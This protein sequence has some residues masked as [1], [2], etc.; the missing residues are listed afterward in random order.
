MLGQVDRRTLRLHVGHVHLGQFDRGEV[1]ADRA[2][3]D[4]AHRERVADER[5]GVQAGEDDRFIAGRG[6][7]REEQVDV[8]GVGD[9]VRVVSD[10]GAD[11]TVEPPPVRL[12]PAGVGLE[13][14]EPEVGRKIGGGKVD[15][16]DQRRRQVGDARQ[17]DD[18]AGDRVPGVEL[19]TD[20]GH[21]IET[22]G[23]VEP[24]CGGDR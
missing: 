4:A 16:W 15:A 23:P 19:E 22:V 9:V 18:V 2:A 14:P 1:N 5:I 6:G 3:E 24:N 12:G 10:L 21:G 8:D 13:L 17:L 20:V 7:G 11:H